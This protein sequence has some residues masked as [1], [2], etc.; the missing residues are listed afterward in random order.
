MKESRLCQNC[1]K[2]FYVHSEDF[3]FYGKLSVPAPLTCP[4]CRFERRLMFRNERTLYKRNCDKC[5][6][7]IV[8]IFSPGG[9]QTV[10][11]SPCW[12]GDSWDQ[13]AYGMDYD[14]A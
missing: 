6:K 11:C 4:G 7:G 1:K 10:Y 5:G 12:W 3:D 9:K 2:D 14:A 13:H 8:T